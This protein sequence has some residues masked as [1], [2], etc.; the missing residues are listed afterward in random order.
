VMFSQAAERGDAFA[1][2]KIAPPAIDTATTAS[3][4]PSEQASL[5]VSK[6]G[7]VK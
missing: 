3:V 4:E 5:A 2:S 6:T 7:R 1:Q